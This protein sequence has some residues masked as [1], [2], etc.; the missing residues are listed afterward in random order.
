MI[1]RPHV[2]GGWLDPH[3]ADRIHGTQRAL[4]SEDAIEDARSILRH[5]QHHGDGGGEVGR[6]S[7]SDGAQRLDPA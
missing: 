1:G 3:A 6:E 5:V 7:R 4:A 2:D